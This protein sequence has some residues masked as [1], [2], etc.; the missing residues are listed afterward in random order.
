M[1]RKAL[2]LSLAIHAAAFWVGKRVPGDS[3]E[4]A[5]TIVLERDEGGGNGSSVKSTKP[6]P[7]QDLRFSWKDAPPGERSSD[8]ARESS[9]EVSNRLG[10]QNW[11]F[12]QSLDLVKAAHYQSFFGA[13]WRRLDRSIGYPDDFA[14]ERIEGIVTA[15]ALLG[16]NGVI[17]GESLEVG[18]DKQALEL[19]VAAILSAVLLSPLPERNW[20]ET[21]SI[22]VNFVIQFQVHTDRSS[23][24][25]DLGGVARNTLTLRRHKRM[26]GKVN[27]AIQAFYKRF[28]PPILPMPGG[29]II[30]F[31]RLYEMIDEW[32]RPTPGELRQYRMEVFKRHLKYEAERRGGVD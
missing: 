14:H 10:Q 8:K 6:K 15:R 16:H 18:S 13:L 28:I 2:L 23:S 27:E 4:S 7:R 25:T 5:G 22:P 20:A 31:V 30:D 3:A 1:F 32:G 9:Q 12:G 11:E 21:E 17:R 19:Y 24:M 26:E 29:F